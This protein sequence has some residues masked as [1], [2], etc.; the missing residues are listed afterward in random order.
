MTDDGPQRPMNKLAKTAHHGPATLVWCGPL[1]L[2]PL[3]GVVTLLV[4]VACCLM[5]RLL[6]CVLRARNTK[7]RKYEDS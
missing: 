1:L 6:G 7:R 2:V 3:G 4:F 5:S